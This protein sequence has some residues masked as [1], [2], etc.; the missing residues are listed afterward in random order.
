MMTKHLGRAAFVLI[1]TMLPSFIGRG[2]L[3]MTQGQTLQAYVAEAP[4]FLLG[5]VAAASV[6]ILGMFASAS[7]SWMIKPPRALIEERWNDAVR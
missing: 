2:L 1:L 4:P 3:A 6:L 5:L 7:L